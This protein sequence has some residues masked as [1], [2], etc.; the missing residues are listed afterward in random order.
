MKHYII[1]ITITLVS[2][3]YAN[4]G[5]IPK[6]DEN[7]IL[8]LFLFSILSFSLLSLLFFIDIKNYINKKRKNKNRSF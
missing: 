2:F 6:E 5:Y 4:I 8:G 3:F 7:M 1:L